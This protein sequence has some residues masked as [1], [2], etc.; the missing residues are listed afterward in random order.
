MNGRRKLTL[1]DLYSGLG[2]LSLGFE[3]TGS[4][5][6]L[7]GL[8]FY[9]PAVETFYSYHSPRSPILS[10]P[11]DLT[12]LEPS[13]VLDELGEAP[14]LIVGGPPCQGFSHAGRRLESIE[15][16]ERN[17]Q[18]LRFL[19][20]VEKM[21]P[22]AF[23]MENVSG[24]LLTGQDSRY[25]LLDNL[26]RHYRELGYAVSFKILNTAE[27]RVP[28]NRKRLILVGIRGAR[29]PFVFPSPPCDGSESGGLGLYEKVNTV[30]DA[31]SDLPTPTEDEPQDY[32]LPPQTA[33]QAFLRQGSTCLHNHLVTNHSAE[34]LRKLAA[35]AVGTRLYPKWNHS[36]YRLNPDKPSPAVK[37]NHRAPFV[38][39][40][41]DR[42][43]SPRECA[44]LQTIPDR[45][46]L[47]RTKTHGLIMI[48]N[49]V[50]PIFSAHLATALAKQ[51]FNVDVEV[52]WSVEH[53]PLKR[54][55]P[56][57][58]KIPAVPG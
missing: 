57:R 42:A 55:A 30:A 40:S 1:L 8:D 6:T 25:E 13:R 53:N 41:E 14:D 37:E 15:E 20:Y 33:L 18:V 44:R 31:L 46:R 47:G 26:T 29:A 45:I 49:A 50:P 4:F 5:S 9:P 3:F 7:A 28:Q 19:H 27:F 16:D 24:I 2:G 12:R 10:Q 11:Q 38:H 58:R 17:I 22:K 32:E 54:L 39:F 48:G 23:L 51:A 35:Q 56:K 43:T 21:R 36:W 52:P 34:M